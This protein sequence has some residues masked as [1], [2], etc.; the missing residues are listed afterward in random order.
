M[1]DP[2]FGL[3]IQVGRSSFK[4]HSGTTFRKDIGLPRRVLLL[5]GPTRV[6]LFRN[7]APLSTWTEY[8]LKVFSI[9]HISLGNCHHHF[10]AHLK[11]K[12]IP[13]LYVSLPRSIYIYICICKYLYI[14]PLYVFYGAWDQRI[15][16]SPGPYS[17]SQGLRNSSSSGLRW[18][19]AGAKRM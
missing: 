2:W 6:R 9:L 13:W 17:I 14:Y 8:W 16:N 10:E 3:W 18:L 1:K 19:G 5:Y 11:D 7:H 12:I 15:G 4:S